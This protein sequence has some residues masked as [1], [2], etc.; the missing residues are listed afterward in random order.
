M[1]GR[2]QGPVF[3]FFK[4]LPHKHMVAR[5]TLPRPHDSAVK[6]CYAPRF[7]SGTMLKSAANRLYWRNN[8]P[9]IRSYR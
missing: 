2:P 7:I 6:L 8:D 4:R 3:R 9:F 5:L 1:K